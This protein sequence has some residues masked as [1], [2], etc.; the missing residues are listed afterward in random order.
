MYYICK[1]KCDL[2]GCCKTTDEERA[3]FESIRKEEGKK[4]YPE[5]A[6]VCWIYALTLD[7]YGIGPEL[8]EEYRQVGREYFARAPG[9]EI[10]V[11]FGD[12]PEATSDSLWEMHKDELAFRVWLP[13]AFGRS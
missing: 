12:L 7:P 3:E 9:G 4:I 8:P 11:P 10:W 2:K 1:I 5:T 6:E 13:E